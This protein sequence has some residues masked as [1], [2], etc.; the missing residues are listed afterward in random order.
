MCSRHVAHMIAEYEAA[1][2]DEDGEGKERHASRAS[3][4]TTTDQTGLLA[5]LRDRLAR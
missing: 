3:E 1:R 5:A 2:L 4:R